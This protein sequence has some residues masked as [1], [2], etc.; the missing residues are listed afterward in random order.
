MTKKERKLVAKSLSTPI[1]DPFVV[2][3][4]TLGG[5]GHSLAMLNH[6]FDETD[7]AKFMVI[8]VDQDV[9]ALTESAARIKSP[10]FITHR[11]NFGSLTPS[12][13][14]SLC[15]GSGG[16]AD[17]VLLDLGVSSHQIDDPKRG[18]TYKD[19]GPL[20]MR[21][22]DETEMT[23]ATICNNWPSTALVSM[24]MLHADETPSQASRI[25]TAIIES[26]PLN[27]TK[28]LAD[29]VGKVVPQWHKTSPRKGLTKTLSRIFQ[30]LRVTVNGEDTVLK[31]VLR[32]LPG[33]VREGGK[34]AVLTYQSMEDKLVKS[35]FKDS[36]YITENGRTMIQTKP[37][38]GNRVHKDLYG[39][40]LRKM[41][42]KVIDS[43]SD[44]S[45][46]EVERNR[47]S[48]SARLRVG[49]LNEMQ[50]NS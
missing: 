7:V 45:R 37:L 17:F 16:K 46:E 38:V 14:S 19:S 11:S 18:F 41:V 34:V 22:S 1:H 24:F 39:N 6:M 15:P 47:R 2:L 23:A 4:L 28:D 50:C 10:N 27:T 49:R 36:Q 30:A 3:D 5:G 44:A 35:A 9:E 20:D 26:R 32:N 13:I 42:W 8:G 21:M 31:D 25:A 40:D 43:G 12:A 29:A 48:R 33:L